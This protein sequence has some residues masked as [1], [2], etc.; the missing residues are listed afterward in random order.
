MTEHLREELRNNPDNEYHKLK[1]IR[2]I[3]I[4]DIFFSFDNGELIK[5]LRKRG[6]A[7]SRMQFDEVRKLDEQMVTMLK[8]P[9]MKNKF[10][11]PTVARIIFEQED[12]QTFALEMSKQ[13]QTRPEN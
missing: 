13:N 12:A 1:I 9:I 4:A 10:E 2:E 6:Y 5:I 11:T 8:D 7:I 3:K